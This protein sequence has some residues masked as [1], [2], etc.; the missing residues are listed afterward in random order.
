[1]LMTSIWAGLAA[2]A[3]I[4]MAADWYVWSPRYQTP[5][6]GMPRPVNCEDYRVGLRNAA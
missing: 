4:L 5:E 2:V 1:M 3:A 6:A